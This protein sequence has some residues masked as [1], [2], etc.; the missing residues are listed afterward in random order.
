MAEIFGRQM[1]IAR[2]PTGAYEENCWYPLADYTTVEQLKAY[3]FP[4][5]DGGTTDRCQ[6]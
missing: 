6:L 3:R 2:N 4:D 5:P 1:R